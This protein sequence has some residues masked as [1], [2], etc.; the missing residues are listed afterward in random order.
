MKIEPN[1]V[2]IEPNFWEKS[3]W[4][5]RNCLIS[6]SQRVDFQTLARTYP[7]PRKTSTPPGKDGEHIKRKKFIGGE[8][9]NVYIT[10]L[11]K[12]PSKSDLQ[13]F[14]KNKANK[15]RLQEFLKSQ[16]KEYVSADKKLIYS[17][18]NKCSEIKKYGEVFNGEFLKG[19]HVGFRMF[20]MK[21]HFI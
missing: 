2:K 1:L 14:F 16:F 17:T 4:G 3:L 19:I 21:Y 18:R 12:L 8:A 20:Q 15:I 6:V 10:A 7:S 11:K 9:P 13:K 5:S